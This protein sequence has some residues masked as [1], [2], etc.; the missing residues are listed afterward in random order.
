MSSRADA[1]VWWHDAQMDA[2]MLATTRR[3]LHGV[4]ELL[5]AGPQYRATGTIRLR[6]TP[7]GFGGLVSDARVDGTDLVRGHRRQPLTGTADQL[8]DALDIDVGRPAGLYPDTSGVGAGDPLLVDG[9][10][11]ELIASWFAIGD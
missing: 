6:V 9:A 8:A 4:A 10:A 11:A 2:D 7:G 3:S 1:N 5:I